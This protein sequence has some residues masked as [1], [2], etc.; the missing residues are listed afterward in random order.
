MKKAI[1][2]LV[3]FFFILQSSL[4][5]YSTNPKD[6]VYELVNDAI[7]NL[8]DK[9]LDNEQ[10]ALYIEKNSLRERRYKC[11]LGLYTLGELRK[12]SNK[13]D[14]TNYQKSFEKYF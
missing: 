5:S 1:I 4:F 14:I 7:N 12:S 10:K 13:D 9:N 6:F 3:S 2:Y 11:T 8:N